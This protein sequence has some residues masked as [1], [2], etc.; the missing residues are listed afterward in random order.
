MYNI[1]LNTPEVIVIDDFLPEEIQDRILNQVQVDKWQSTL[2]DD[3]F[4]HM[5]DGINYKG[6]KR[7]YSDAPFNDNYDLWFDNLSKFLDTAKN[8]NHVVP[9]IEDG[10]FDIAL[11]CHAYPVGSKNPWHFD[12]GFSTYTYYL[13]KNWQANWDS[14]LLVLPEGSV[15]FEQ[16]LPLKEG[17]VH[18][19]S[20]ADLES[21]MEMFEQSDKF[22]SIIDKGFG[23]FVSPKPNRLVLIKAGVVHGINRVDSD[24]GYNIRV[25]LTGAIAEKSYATRLP[26]F[27]NMERPRK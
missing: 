27:A 22:K 5:T 6:P 4:W 13:H 3:K 12:L 11:R 23:T 26:R 21:P 17:T 14:T 15:D 24:A 2:V 9:G 25:S 10:I 18:Y 16:V 1:V 20:Y 8:I 19:D 7:W